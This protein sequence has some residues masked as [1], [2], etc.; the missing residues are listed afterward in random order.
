MSI[1]SIPLGCRGCD[2]I[3]PY[4]QDVQ[5]LE[6]RQITPEVR[7][8]LS[9]WN[10]TNEEIDQADA[11]NAFEL[12]Q[13]QNALNEAAVRTVGCVGIQLFVVDPEMQSSEGIEA[14]CMSPFES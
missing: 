4:I 1:E 14:I 3:L 9:K 10:F 6:S 8:K 5:R 11:D 12:Q 13:S 2:N 7:Q